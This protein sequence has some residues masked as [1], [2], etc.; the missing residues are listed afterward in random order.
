MSVEVLAC[1][2]HIPFARTH[3]E[4]TNVNGYHVVMDTG[5]KD[6]NVSVS[7]RFHIKVILFSSTL[8]LRR[9]SDGNRSFLFIIFAV[10]VY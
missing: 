10:L 3:V 8:T 4:A 6:Q 5:L 9:R 1:V 7:C 2:R